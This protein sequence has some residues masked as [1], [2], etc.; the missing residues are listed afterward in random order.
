MTIDGFIDIINANLTDET[1]QVI[2]S[3]M[4]KKLPHTPFATY[5]TLGDPI[6]DEIKIDTRTETEEGKLQEEIS[7]RDEVELTLKVYSTDKEEALEAR[8]SLYRRIVAVWR[9]EINNSGFGLVRYSLK[10]SNHQKV[11]NVYLY[12]YMLSITI[13]YNNT[14]EKE[15]EKLT[16][17]EITGDIEET[18]TIID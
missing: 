6:S 16:T 15:I 11:D 8:N 1:L 9:E 12:C 4:W 13:D 18:E 10:G 17:I 2:P 5:D 7:F 3:N 14:V